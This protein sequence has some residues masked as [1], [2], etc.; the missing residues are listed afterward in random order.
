[1]IL[2]YRYQRQGEDSTKLPVPRQRD[3]AHQIATIMLDE[4]SANLVLLP[5]VPYSLSISLSV[6]YRELRFSKLKRHKSEARKKL[7]QICGSLSIL[8][9]S[10]WSAALMA[11]MTQS[12]LMQTSHTPLP[13]RRHSP[14]TQARLD[15]QNQREDISMDNVPSADAGFIPYL[16]NYD[17]STLHLDDLLGPEWN[18]DAMD[19]L[20]QDSFD[21]SIPAFMK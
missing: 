21:P 3:A 15:A 20:I 11:E 5:F 6:A 19:C 18:L 2:S 12:V 17:Q 13:S 7:H 8:G 10:Y 16:P 14:S 1:M 9:A 4:G